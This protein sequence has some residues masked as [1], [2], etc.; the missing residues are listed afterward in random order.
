MVESIQKE[1]QNLKHSRSRYVQNIHILLITLCAL[2]SRAIRLVE[3]VCACVY[4]EVYN[5]YG[6]RASSKSIARDVTFWT[7]PYTSVWQPPCWGH[8]CIAVIERKTLNVSLFTNTSDYSNKTCMERS[9]CLYLTS[10]VVL[11]E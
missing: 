9:M 7:I 2:R 4:N 3:S 5:V 8:K 1:N 11:L 6:P 10:I